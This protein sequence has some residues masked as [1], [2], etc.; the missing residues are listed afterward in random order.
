MPFVLFE[1]TP[2][3]GEGRNCPVSHRGCVK[4][5][6]A[7]RRPPAIFA[8]DHR[9]QR[10][11]TVNNTHLIPPTRN[12]PRRKHTITSFPSSP[13][14]L[15]PLSA[16]CP[17][18]GLGHFTALA[19][20]W[21]WSPLGPSPLLPW[22]PLAPVPLLALLAPSQ[23]CPPFGLVPSLTLTPCSRDIINIGDIGDPVTSINHF[24]LLYCPVFGWDT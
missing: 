24:H 8:W 21:P 13:L 18:L 16:F 7:R 17:P 3:A 19:L 2:L 15:V 20:F 5:R 9:A 10:V 1:P 11:R 4:I 22:P 14:K 23:P 12:S 6:K